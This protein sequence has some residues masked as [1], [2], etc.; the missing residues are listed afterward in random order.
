MERLAEAA[1]RPHAAGGGG[2][3][4]KVSSP[5]GR[6]LQ[7]RARLTSDD[8]TLRQTAVYY[9]PRTGRPGSPR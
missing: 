6:Y 4:G 1:R 5:P 7:F 2:Q 9:L 8:A 3:R